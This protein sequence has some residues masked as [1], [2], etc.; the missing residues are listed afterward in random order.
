MTEVDSTVLGWLVPALVVFGTAAL[1]ILITIWLVRR[2]R[3]SPKA[4]AAAGVIRDSAGAALVRLDDEVGELDL[5]V[6]LSGAMYGGG[7]PASLHRALLTAQH[8]RDSSFEEYR[9]LGSPSLTPDEIRRRSGRIE[10]KVATAMSTISH[11]RTEHVAWMHANVS[12]AAQVDAARGRL[13]ALRIAMGEPQRLIDD[14]S[15]RFAEDEWRAAARAA[16][17]AFA[18]AAEAERLL[19][20][21][22]EEAADPSRS[23]LADVARAERSLRQ[24]EA[25]ARAL[26]ETH[27]LVTQAAQAVPSEFEAARAALRQAEGIRQHL[28]PVDAERLGT[29]VRAVA[30][31]LDALEADAPR[32]PT[33]TVDR[34]VRLRDRL[35]FALGDARTAQQRL[36][37]ARTALPGT[38]ASARGMIAR[39]EASVSHARAGAPARLRLLSAER[40]L[41]EARQAADPVE[42]LDAARRAMRDAEDASALAD[43]DRLGTP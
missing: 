25:D 39:A 16:E 33:H 30:A 13:A 4:R 7:A 2:I 31:A 8:V 17:S 20:V 36:R 34:I 19:S 32:R 11:A 9:A 28:E 37:G 10:R 5:E 12:A 27:R 14:L 43:Y 3:R 15:S 26:E 18:E 29:E 35:D 21:A 6:G 22:A 42:A 1:L 23:S 24:A 38:L 40:E 41:A